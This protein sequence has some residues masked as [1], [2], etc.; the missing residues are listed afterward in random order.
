VVKP[1]SRLV[2]CLLKSHGFAQSLKMS[3][4]QR[5]AH[6]LAASAF[7]QSVTIGSQ[8]LLT[9]LFFRHWG[10]GLYGEWLILSSVPAYLTMSDLGIGS[11]AGNEMTMKAGA[12]DLT[13][14]QRTYRGAHWV[15]F[16][17]AILGCLIGLA[18]AAMAT[19]LDIPKTTLISPTDGGAII[20]MLAFGIG[21]NFHGSV[22]GCWS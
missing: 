17:A 13:G 5:I 11:A 1:P 18:L 16:A 6:A 15:A 7:G 12:D 4:K 10:P 21:I 3:V 8:L 9:P 20:A 2:G 14:A 22:A 19:F